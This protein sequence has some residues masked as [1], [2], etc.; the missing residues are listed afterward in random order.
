MGS[1]QDSHNLAFAESDWVGI[2]GVPGGFRIEKE[3]KATWVRRFDV[4]VRPTWVQLGEYGKAFWDHIAVNDGT[5]F[6]TDETKSR[7]VAT[8][9]YPNGPSKGYT[10]FQSTIPRGEWRDRMLRD[11]HKKKEE[12]TAPRW[13]WAAYT[14]TSAGAATKLEIHAE[15]GAAFLCERD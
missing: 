11:R 3:K 13:C 12:R 7:I 4:G 15:D 9:C 14:P 5:H 1:P 2:A 8:M 6:R 10:I